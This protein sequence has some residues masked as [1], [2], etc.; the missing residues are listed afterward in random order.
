MAP[1]LDAQTFQ[2]TYGGA[3]NDAAR[4]GVLVIPGNGY[5]TVGESQSFGGNN[6]VYVVRTDACGAILW[7]A[8]YDIGGNDVGHKIRQTADGGFII[9]G[10]TENLNNC[11]TRNDIFLLKITAGGAV[12]WTRTYGGNDIEEGRDVQVA[13]NGYVVAGRTASFGMGGQDGYL[14][15]TDLLGNVVWA[16]AYGGIYNDFF[17]SCAIAANGDILGFGSTA[18]YTTSPLDYDFYLARVAAATGAPNAGFPVHY[19]NAL[20]FDNE[21]GW[22]VFENGAGNIVMAGGTLSFGSGRSDGLLIEANAAGNRLCDMVYGDTGWDEF[23]EIKPATNGTY[24]ITGIL[25]NPNGGFGGYDMYIGNVGPCFGTI[26]HSIHGGPGDDMGYGLAQA[27]GPTVPEVIAVG[28]TTSFGSGGEDIYSVR[29]AANGIS[30]C[31]DRII[32]LS[33]EVPNLQAQPAPAYPSIIKASC[34]A[35]ATSLFHAR[36]TQLCTSCNPIPPTLDE[37]S[38]PDLGMR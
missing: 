17:L 32:S 2:W 14:M 9:V 6:D 28:S 13:G 30:G 36:Q 37:T 4:G 18:S 33:A 12:V 16:R 31:N 8:T 23:L 1:S 27:F 11:C 26:M 19:S 34:N 25:F 35:L 7:S 5:I 24:L 3:A 29:T 10:E 22:S 15:M 38:G 21:I 20:S